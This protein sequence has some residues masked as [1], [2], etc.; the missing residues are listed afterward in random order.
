MKNILTN[1]NRV[2]SFLF[3]AGRKI[4]YSFIFSFC[5]A[6]TQ[7]Q[8]CSPATAFDYLDI[9]NVKARINNGG[10]M[11]WN[12]GNSA[13]Y[14]VP[15]SGNVSSLFAGS[16]W[17]GGLDEQGD[18]HI[19]AQTYRQNGNDFFPGPL[20]A[21]GNVTSQVCNEFDRIWKV[22]KSTIDSFTAGLFATTPSS[23]LQWPGRNNPDLSFLPDQ[24]LA[25]F[26]DMNGDNTY[27]PSDGDY[28]AVP[29]DQALW[30]VFNDNGNVHGETGGAPLGIEIQCLAYA[31]RD[32]AACTYST[33]LY[34]YRI[35]NKSVRN[36]TNVYVGLW[37]DPD[38]GCYTDDYAGT[39]SSDNLGI[40]YNGQ[41]VDA[42][43]CIDNYGNM[44]PVLALQLLRGPTDLDGTVH[45]LDHSMYY[46][47]DFS[48]IGNPEIG[49]DYYGY[50][51]SVW[52][53]GSHLTAGG[54]GYGGAQP[55]NY[56][57][58]GD[59]SDPY[60]WSMCSSNA[61]FLDAR[62]IISSGPLSL[63]SGEKKTFDFAAVWDNTSVYPCPSY[64]T[65]A[66]VATCVKE[67]FISDV[68]FTGNAIPSFAENHLSVFPNPA[69]SS[70]II[71]FSGSN[72]LKAE[73]FDLTGRKVFNS[74]FL[75]A[76]DLKL[77]ST[78]IGKGLFIYRFT[79]IDHSSQSGKLVIQ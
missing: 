19:A 35:I 64:S 42:N 15:Q 43:S 74:G 33:T 75:Q 6:G 44:P 58:T 73:I 34:H 29:G 13:E 20:D 25:P 17:I 5:V 50:L 49:D 22:N 41:A 56:F 60:G 30:F 45:Y 46:L 4:F 53:D 11:W 40:V 59:P 52:K 27:N 78:Q 79:F 8:N 31:F 61:V 51:K 68:V 9:N 65:I 38:L 39:D 37:S 71:N 77:N 57:Y 3:P 1:S 63:N 2:I 24:E 16:L 28:P 62:L 12:L 26:I 21:S 47:N 10:D 36:Y 66:D 67:S 76:E 32:T 18:L 14:I 54:N 70:S 69:P 23:I 48:V 55:S 72:I 7:A